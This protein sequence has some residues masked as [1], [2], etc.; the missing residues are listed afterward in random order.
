[1]R[2]EWLV[3]EIERIAPRCLEA[4]PPV[5]VVCDLANAALA[6][7]ARIREGESPYRQ[8]SFEPGTGE[9]AALVALE[10]ALEECE[11]KLAHAEQD[12]AK[13]RK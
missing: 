10:H 3:S 4:D 1:M 6:L 13:L 7:A 5:D 8:S 2:L 12:L 9:H 11:E